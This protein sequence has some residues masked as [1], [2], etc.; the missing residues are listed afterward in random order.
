[1]ADETKEINDIA[2]IIEKV[3]PYYA[4]RAKQ[5]KAGVLD[6]TASIDISLSYN[7]SMEGLEPMYFWILDFL[8][9]PDK[10]IKLVDTFNSS[11]GSG[12][13]SDLGMKATK[14]QEESMKIMQ[15]I[16][17]L[18]KSVIQILY[19][20]RQF[21]IRLNDYNASN[22][23]DIQEKEAGIMALKQIWLDNVDIKRGNSGIKA[24]TFSQQGTFGTL[25]NAFFA[26]NSQED[27]EKIDLNDIVKRVLKQRFLEFEEWKS[28][29][30]K[31]LRKRY[32]MEKA[33]L[34]SQVDSLKLYSRWAM[35]YL[36]AAEDLRMSSNLGESAALVKAFNTI[37]LRLTLMQKK[38]I[39]VDE[40]VI[41]K[42]LPAGFERLKNL[43]KYYACVLVDF[44]FRGIPQR[45]DQHYAFGGKA[46]VTF[47][48]YAL[49]EDEFELFNAEMEKSDI[50]N[51]LKLVESAA[52]ASLKE[53]QDEL[54]AFLNEPE[55]EISGESKKEE[56][57]KENKKSEDTN[58]FS[59]L[60][61]GFDF[62]SIFKK[63]EKKK[64]EKAEKKEKLEK[65][66]KGIK[67]D[68]YAEKVIRNLTEHKARG[69]A[70]G[71]YDIYKKSHGM[72]SV[73]FDVNWGAS[74]VDVSFGDVIKNK[75]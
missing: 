73:P 32:K 21:K 44:K 70:F 65:L 39:K 20:L 5:N 4:Q 55:E 66:K 62:S 9:G 56:E 54:D 23:K 61:G 22:A 30:E 15:T 34:R 43:R 33:W 36:K 57:K 74:N 71:V 10:V 69:S 40:S 67:P 12:H 38:E 58:P 75:F 64:D 25:L 47:K 28:L 31:E 8:G 63:E 52:G 29:S 19:D 46:D 24:M 13:F 42:E 27:V 16:G 41:S 1:M 45:V 6:S 7:S 72:A 18:V 35:P 48:A 51:S 59:A 37:L 17:V 11:V 3:S 2:S 53:I 14:M 50:K 60:L 49:N 68:N 26:I